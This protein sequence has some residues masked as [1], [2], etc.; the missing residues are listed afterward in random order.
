MCYD[1]ASETAKSALPLCL[2]GTHLM[3]SAQRPFD[4]GAPPSNSNRACAHGSRLSASS[5]CRSRKQDCPTNCHSPCSVPVEQIHRITLA[6][7]A[8]IIA[9]S[10]AVATQVRVDEV[11]PPERVSVVLNGIDTNRFENA[12]SRF[13]RERF[14]ASWGLPNDALLIWHGGRA[15]AAQRS[16]G[17]S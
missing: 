6:K 7:A 13:N 10:Q 15:D 12:R 3:P 17:I 8:R 2:C 14:L 1:R 11:A 4:T 16:G 5:L 9:V